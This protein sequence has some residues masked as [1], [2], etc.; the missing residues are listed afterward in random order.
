VSGRDPSR[1]PGHFQFE[2]P[3]PDPDPTAVVDL[4]NHLVPGVDD[5]ARDL[6]AVLA[7]VERMVRVGIRKIVTTPHIDASLTLDPTA[8]ERRLDEV[9]RAWER[10][11][12]ALARAFPEVDYRRG[13]EVMLDVPDGDLG[14]ARLRLAGTDYVLVEWPRMRVPP[15]T[16]PVVA[17]L[18][19]QGL[20][21]VVA[22]PERYAGVGADLYVVDQW[23]EAGAYLQVNYGSFVGRYG[24]EART[25]AFRFLRRGWIDFLA[26]D[27]HGQAGMRIYKTQA[28]DIL[29]ELGASEQL[30]LLSVTNPARLLRNERPHAVPAV[31][32]ERA[33]FWSRLKE[34]LGAH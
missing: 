7:A 23:R 27:F 10:A 9:T 32:E 14:D 34:L 1:G 28:W 15:G 26:S 19:E 20:R 11:A 13:H 8:L 12:E 21:P 24:A 30:E 2:E 6:P 3:G 4:H 33:G 5:G 29:R 18:V 31:P 16:P 25:T 22:H 17:R